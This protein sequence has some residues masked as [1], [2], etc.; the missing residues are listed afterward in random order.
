MRKGRCYV[1]IAVY[2]RRPERLEFWHLFYV[3]AGSGSV[4]IQEPAS[5]EVISLKKWR[6]KTS[7]GRRNG[8]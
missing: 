8:A 1:A 2:A 5:G 7:A 3:N 4:L 6:A